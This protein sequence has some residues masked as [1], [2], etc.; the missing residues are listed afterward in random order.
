MLAEYPGMKPELCKRFVDNVAGATFCS[1]QELQ[2]FL[3]FASNYHSRIDFTWSVSA[4]KL[5]FLDIYMVSRDNCIATSVYYKNTDSHSYL[6]FR[7]SH[8]AKCKS[9]ILYSQFL[10]LWKICSDQDDFQNGATTMETY[11]AACGY[12]P[13]LI[14]RACDLA[15]AKWREDLLITASGNDTSFDC[16]TLV[17]T[18][19]PKNVQVCKILLWNYSISRDDQNT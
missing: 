12:P 11:F 6:D 7:S 13:D 10:R 15:E 17:L 19:H 8:L 1:E 9:S 16:P 2:Q 4:D 3:E 14:T 18:Y 5:P